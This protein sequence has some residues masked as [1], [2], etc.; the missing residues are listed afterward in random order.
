[1]FGTL[2]NPCHA[3]PA[4]RRGWAD[5]AAPFVGRVNPASLPAS[6]L[7]M[8][9]GRASGAVLCN[10]AMTDLA[11]SIARNCMI[12]SS[13][14]P[15][16][17]L[18]DFIRDYLIA[19]FRFDPRRPIPYKRYA[20]KPEQGI[21]F[22]V[23]GR[24][25]IRDPLTGQAREA[26]SVAIFGQQVKRCDVHLAHEFLM[27]RVH[28]QPGA[29][30][31]LLGIPLYEFGEDYFDAEL[32]LSSDVRDVT[33][34]LDTAATY[35]EMV[36]AVES[37]LVRSAARATRK[38]L[39]VDRAA[40]RLT[41]DPV[42][43]SL[44]WLARQAFLSPRQL[45][46]RFTE[47]IGVGPKLY[48]RLLRFHRAYLFKVAHPTIA[49][50]TVAHEFGYTDYQHMVRDFKQFTNA[51]PTAWLQEDRGSPEN[52]LRDSAAG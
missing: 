32:V 7:E 17:G 39:P 43:V 10:R 8:L 44:D 3:S 11:Y 50:P 23:R 33:D 2:R 13:I 6:P 21:T 22:F 5:G 36:E 4:L 20:P 24:P 12:F 25:R 48:G 35:T 9:G 47:R 15:S 40:G 16:P 26:P 29:L 28:F 14:A 38:V 42:H 37:Y 18:Q 49:W 31:R 41:A 1:M 46:R 52:A 34:R 19:H 45:N 27:F 30:F 51:T